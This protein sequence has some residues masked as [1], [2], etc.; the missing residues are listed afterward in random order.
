MASDHPSSDVLD[1]LDALVV[2]F[3]E[4]R[5]GEATWHLE[6][7]AAMP[8]DTTVGSHQRDAALLVSL[9][10]LH[11]M[12]GLPNGLAARNAACWTAALFAL[13]EVKAALVAG[14]DKPQQPD[15]EACR[16]GYASCCRQVR[17]S[18][19]SRPG[20]VGAVLIQKANGSWGQ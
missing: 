14:G 19:L 12:G 20:R 18:H 15:H 9:R 16:P 2:R 10:S 6:T 17:H 5:T 11:S 13:Q 4:G 7:T 8:V 3:S 1:A